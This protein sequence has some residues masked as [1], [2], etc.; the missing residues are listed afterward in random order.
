MK[1]LLIVLLL[2]PA[3]AFADNEAKIACDLAKAQAEVIASELK[4]PSVFATGSDQISQKSIALGVSESLSGLVRASKIT[5]AAEAQCASLQ[6]SVKLDQYTL[7]SIT[8]IQKQGAIASL[9]ILNSAIDQAIDNIR[10]LNDQLQASVVT[11]S[12][13]ETA[14]LELEALE[15][16]KATLLTIISAVVP[17]IEATDI[18]RLVHDYQFNQGRAAELT[19]KAQAHGG[20]DITVGIGENTPIGSQPPGTST[21]AAPF[22]TAM[23]KYSLGTHAAMRA[24]EEV[25]KNTQ[26]LLQNQQTGYFQTLDR[27]RKEVHALIDIDTTNLANAYRQLKSLRRIRAPL[28]TV[29]SLLAGNARRTL[30]LHIK[31]TEADFAGA[32]TRLT[33]LRSLFDKMK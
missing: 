10:I 21:D 12:D 14:E 9:M 13:I 16:Q 1:I 17:P 30:D 7:W 15:K 5:D 28:D 33:E 19:A 31:T 18:S 32:T 22:F 8:N 11:V 25:G 4:S 23:V 27:H 26:L 2:M 24:A 29:D 3:I 20:W 6:A